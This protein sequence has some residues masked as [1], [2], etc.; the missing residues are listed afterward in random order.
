[1]ADIDITTPG[2]ST[3]VNGVI[4]TR[5]DAIGS[6][7]GTY[8][9]F[10]AI[11][12]NDGNEN[13]FNT[14]ANGVLNTDQSKT[15]SLTFNQIPIRI[16]DGV[17]YLEFRLDLNE[18]NENP[19]TALNAMK[20]YYSSAPATGAD[21]VAGTQ[22]LDAD[23][24]KIFDLD[25][26]GDKTLLMDAHSS[27]S[28][29]DDYI[30]YVPVSLFGG[31][32]LSTAYITMYAEFGRAGTTYN[33]D[34][35]FEEFNTEKAAIIS[36]VKFL[37]AD[38]D[39]VQDAGEAG[40][41]GWTIFVDENKNGVLDAG[42]RSTVTKADGTFQI[43]GLP[44]SLGTVQ[45]DEVL[46]E[47]W[48]QTT[49]VF[50]TVT[51]AEATTY[52]VQI[53]NQPIP[54]QVDV[55]KTAG[56]RTDGDGNGDDAGDTQVFNFTV[57]NTGTI[58][59]LNVTLMDDN[60]TPGNTA[61]D[62]PITLA[63][64]TDQDGDG[65]ADDLAVG[66]SA[67]G[68]LLHVFTQAE[69]EAGG[70]TNTGT[71]TGSSA[72]GISVSDS[73][74]E[75]VTLT[76]N[77]ALNITKDASVPGGTADAAGEQISYTISVAN[78]GNVMLDGVT[79]T[80]PYADAGSIVRG[81]DT[82]GDNDAL[83][84]VGEVWSY[85]AK[86]TV[87]QGEIDSN[88]GGDGML[89]NTATADSNQT[90]P[91]TDDA[92]VPVDR[93]PS[94]NITKDATVP[95]GTADAAGEQISY[96]ITVANTGNTTLDGVTVTDP[97]ADAGSIVRGADVVGDNDGLLEVG[98]TWGYTAKH[99]VTQGEIDSNGGGDG[100]LEN[101][102]T[103]DSNQTG[104]D[105]DDA[106]VPVDRRPSLN[107]TKDATVP[108]GTADVAGEQI[109]YVITVANTGNTTLD[110][111]TVTDP[112]ADAGSII[113]GADVVGD[114]DGLLEVG[115]T[116]GYTAK[117]TVTQA[118]LDSN[119]GGDGQ[120][121]NTATADSN[122]TGP[123]T[124][125]ASVPV[126]PRPSLNITKDATVPGG[127]ADTAGEQISYVITVA[128]TGNTTLDGVTV[129][130]PYA[131]AGSIMRGADVVGDNDALLEVGETWGYTAKHTVTQAEIDSNGGGDGQL[132]N[133]ATAD[134]NQT[135]PDTDDASVPVDRRPS[136]NIVKD[137][138]VPG[139]TADVA[140]EQIS[141]TISVT[142]TGNTTLD[143]VTVTDPYADAG[144]LVRGA[145]TV[146]DNDALL[147]VGEVWSYTAKHTVT[148]AEIDSNGGGDGQLENTATAD[149][150][151][152]GPDTDDASVPVDRRP[153][154]NITK[155][156]TV[157]G[158][159][160]DAA[161]EQISYVI[162]VANTG[163][164]TLDGVTVTDPYADAGSIMR[165]AD[166]VGDND[167]LLEVGET[168][169]YTAKHTV[170]QAELDSNGGGDGKLENVATADSNQTGPD[171]D[172]ANVPVQQRASIDIEKYVSIDGGATWSDA[173]DPMG[174][175]A[176][177]GA[178]VMFKFVVANTGNV[179]LT[180]ATVTDSVF[181]LNGAAAGTARALGT[182]AV[183]ASTEFQIT[184]PWTAGQHVNDATASGS[185][186]GGTATDNDLAY[187][188]GL[189]DSV[190]VRTPGFWLS[191]NG[192]TFWD[193]TVG[194]ETKSGPDFP[195]GELLAYNNGIVDGPDPGN[196]NKEERYILLG[197]DNGNG[198]KDVG[199]DTLQ[200]S[201]ALALKVIDASMKPSQDARYVLGRD[202][203][204]AWLNFEAGNPSGDPLD[205][206]S[207]AAKMNQAIDWLQQYA[208]A[209]HDGIADFNGPAVKQNSAAWQG[210][211]AA[212]HTALDDYNNNGTIN[213]FTFAGD[214]DDQLFVSMLTRY[215]EDVLA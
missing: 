211:G 65:Q 123:D 22:E 121:E 62:I 33:A 163:N 176:T 167:G 125:D 97:Y 35:G 112:Y 63:G 141:Y 6:G 66:A 174:P 139:G 144:T 101:T 64:L 165:G 187:Y 135:G 9:P 119:G 145:D 212:L 55:V 181:D 106:S 130:D 183:G 172:D 1:M 52:N 124:D 23:F 74:P 14:D 199:E 117:H 36:G 50:E 215:H 24:T 137:A 18:T 82:V 198:V 107:I 148:Q 185:Y 15:S 206:N 96:V 151:Q 98:E 77:P 10:L 111:V 115:E 26:G 136:L 59:L 94:L 210:S 150:N 128:N 29:N 68:S 190:G 175:I 102:A 76:R 93:R 138:T 41:G 192:L 147:E 153:S 54:P 208:D 88:G 45:V 131:D 42:E 78:T 40:L 16:I 81:A 169:G 146:G 85:T 118:E 87:T 47:G 3:T 75:T 43:G 149:S 72:S 140:G 11:R 178:N 12:D 34:D 51:L 91:D 28:G 71:A 155:D 20:I 17:Q 203:I 67:T 188:F 154:L 122:Q 46:Q 103:A 30:F 116:W 13:G 133:T 79:V 171:T 168:W 164:T 159:T 104:P 48:T 83:L 143:G 197:D 157:P 86:H 207:P 132:E 19:Y 191:P 32:D 196:S 99:T 202:V 193:G 204:A 127:T 100:A 38:G 89:E 113:R 31:A 70:Y 194:N 114:N 4:I 84:E 39:G 173:D 49:G 214:G 53:G 201:L 95:G 158:G 105:T 7:T 161:G 44:L 200:M 152:T 58:K 73:D 8:D 156:A 27:G 109:S 186:S 213:G 179:T 92:N 2:S 195:D 134:S 110:G 205:P 166:V 129:T 184:A 21:Y 108:G 177:S 189:I 160:A 209:N 61:D 25:A 170:T 56:T 126:A 69:I 57:T 37:D 182:L 162:T 90:G 5:G 80:D 120:L 60:G 142:N 180:N